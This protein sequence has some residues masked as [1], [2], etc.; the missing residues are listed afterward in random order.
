MASG[1]TAEVTETATPVD[2]MEVIPTSVEDVSQLWLTVQDLAMDWGIK[3]LAAGSR[4][5]YAAACVA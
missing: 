4:W 2:V 3:V 5:V 1:E